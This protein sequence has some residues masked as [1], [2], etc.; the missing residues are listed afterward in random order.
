M[1]LRRAPTIKF[2]LYRFL[3]V[4]YST[5][6]TNEAL[7]HDQEETF[8]AITNDAPSAKAQAAAAQLLAC[9]TYT[10][11]A[12]MAIVAALRDDCADAD[13]DLLTELA[14][15]VARHEANIV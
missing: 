2:F 8:N 13:A 12:L 10:T 6:M 7:D 5:C 4:P 14:E 1:T 9:C 11:T 3:C 15:R